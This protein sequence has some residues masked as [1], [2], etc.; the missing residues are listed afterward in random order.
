MSGDA[1]A[2]AS[3]PDGRRLALGWW[4]AAE[5][6][7]VL[8]QHGCPDTRWAA[9]PGHDAAR[10]AGVRLLAVNRP[11]YGA[12]DPAPFTHAGWADDV[13]DLLD[14][15]GLAEVAVLGMSVGAGYALTLAARHPGRVRRVV[16]VAGR[17]PHEG[18]PEHATAEDAER[19]F[20]PGFAAWS[21]R[22]DPGDPDDEAVAARF[23]AELPAEDAALLRAARTRAEVAV[24]VR[25]ALASPAGF[26][27]DAA[28]VHRAWNVDPR[29]VACPVHVVQGRHDTAHPPEHGRALAALVPGARL[30]EVPTTHLATLLSRWDHLL[31]LAAGPR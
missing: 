18:P 16:A 27:R 9:A 3:L 12:S 22:V 7:V 14:A 4:G 1:T 28:L 23:L 2:T 26:L 10:A 20:A 31:A 11:G 30:E 13:A 29:T 25:E 5:G 8:F 19:A 15:L 6:P 24:S 17:R 21:A